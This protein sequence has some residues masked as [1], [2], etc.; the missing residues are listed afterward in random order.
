MTKSE[1]K[2]AVQFTRMCKYWKTHECTMG[3]ECTFA[4]SSLELRPSPKPCFEFMK[5]GVCTRGEACRF[6][7]EAPK[8]RAK[9]P[10][11]P[12]P[13][14]AL[15]SFTGVQDVSKAVMLPPGL[16]GP[17]SFRPPPGLTLPSA[18]VSPLQKA[19]VPKQFDANSRRSSLQSELSLDLEPMP[20]PMSKIRGLGDSSPDDSTM[21]TQSTAST[22][23]LSTDTSFWL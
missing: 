23:C 3:T 20:F 7:H 5:R 21:A 18:L 13:D 15:Q 4:H 17:E 22:F 11:L 2:K 6:V 14:L 12:S 9:G 8:P 16:A 1:Q 10:A 19:S